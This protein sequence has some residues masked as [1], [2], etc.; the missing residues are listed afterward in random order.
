MLVFSGTYG[1]DHHSRRIAETFYSIQGEGATAGLPAIFVRL[2]GCTVGCTWCDTKYSWDPTAGREV[3]LP[4][5]LD[6]VAAF[7]A[8][9]CDHG[10]RAARVAALRG[11]R[12]H[13]GR[14]RICRRG[15]DLRHL[16]PAPRRPGIQWKGVAKLSGSGVPEKPASTRPRS[17]PSSRAG[18]VECSCERAGEI[19]EVLQLAERF[20]LRASACCWQPEGLRAEEL[21]RARRGWWRPA[22]RTGFSLLAAAPHPDLGARRGV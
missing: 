7:P 15:R 13:A 21:A 4:A 9:A 19:G 8:V 14:P 12:G 5:L 11:S 16:A 6:E 10:R 3:D 1:V 17:A 20:S 22:R 2:Q 18:L